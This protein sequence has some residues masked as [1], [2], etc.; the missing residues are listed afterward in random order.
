LPRGHG[1]VFLSEEDARK[2]AEG[3]IRL[4]VKKSKD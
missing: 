3:K 2:V 4:E 1:A